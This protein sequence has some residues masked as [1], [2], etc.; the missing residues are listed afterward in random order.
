MFCIEVD[1]NISVLFLVDQVPDNGPWN[2]NFIGVRHSVGMKYGIKLS[3]PRELLGVF[4]CRWIFVR[5]VGRGAVD[6]IW[7]GR[8]FGLG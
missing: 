5:C 7:A 3:I 6:G 2:Y 1:A 8:G 4:R